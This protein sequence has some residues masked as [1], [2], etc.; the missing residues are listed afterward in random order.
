MHNIKLS[1]INMYKNDNSKE[2]PY[3]SVI[4]LHISGNS[5]IMCNASKSI[6]K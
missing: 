6:F 4:Y 3:A 5:Y 2:S 1:N